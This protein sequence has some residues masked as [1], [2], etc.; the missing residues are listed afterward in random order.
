MLNV[1]FPA[2]ENEPSSVNDISAFIPIVDDDI[3]E[4][5]MQTFIVLLESTN[6][7]SITRGVATCNILDNDG[8][9]M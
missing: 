4:A 8:K 2:D 6:A 1:Q 9:H 7:V 3:D 5:P